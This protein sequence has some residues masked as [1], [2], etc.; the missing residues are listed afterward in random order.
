MAVQ[1]AAIAIQKTQV[2]GVPSRA[3]L[4]RGSNELYIMGR[5]AHATIREQL[6]LIAGRENK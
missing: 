3:D 6:L 4:F 2:S 1:S 5:H